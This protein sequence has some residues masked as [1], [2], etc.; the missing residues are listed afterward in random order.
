MRLC[1]ECNIEKPEERFSTTKADGISY[2]RIICK[3]CQ[4]LKVKNYYHSNVHEM[5]RR[6]RVAAKT[7][8]KRRNQYYREYFVGNKQKVNKRA[9][10]YRKTRRKK[11]P[12]FRML[13]NLRTSIRQSFVKN[14]RKK[15]SK[16]ASILCCSIPDF[17]IHIE[18]KMESWMNWDNYGKFNGEKLYGWD[19]DH[20]IP[21]ATANTVEDVIT[22]NHYSN[23]QPLCSYI[24]RIEKRDKII[25]SK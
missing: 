7:H 18:R 14:N 12:V 22:L 16:T 6:G 24:N 1:K 2:L 23:F 13:T 21:L 4:A 5:R 9:A 15:N 8:S 17:K 11:D 3:E 19:L 25:P 10:K 20:I